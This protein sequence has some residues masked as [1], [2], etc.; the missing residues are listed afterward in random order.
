MKGSVTTEPD[1]F[2][3]AMEDPPAQMKPEEELMMI[4][5]EEANRQDYL[6]EAYDRLKDEKAEEEFDSLTKEEQE[7]LK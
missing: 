7:E 5:N 2:D 1:Y 4:E 3:E 6:D